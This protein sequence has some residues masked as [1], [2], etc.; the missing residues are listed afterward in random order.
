MS[1]GHI[2][3]FMLLIGAAGALLVVPGW[4]GDRAQGRRRCPRCWYDMSGGGLVCPECGHDAGAERRLHRGRPRRAVMALGALLV[5]A[6]LTP[7]GVI[8]YQRGGTAALVPTTALIA[9]A[10]VLPDRLLWDDRGGRTEDWTL[11][12]RVRRGGT[13]AWQNRWLNGRARRMVMRSETMREACPAW[14]LASALPRVS[15]ARDWTREGAEHVLRIMLEDMTSDDP[16]TRANAVWWLG[17]S[18]V[19]VDLDRMADTI[20]PYADRLLATA[21]DP[22]KTG[23]WAVS[24]AS[25]C[26]PREAVEAWY[27]LLDSPDQTAQRGAYHQIQSEIAREP[28]AHRARLL[29]MLAGP[30][31][32]R[33]ARAAA[34]LAYD[35]AGGDDVTDALLDALDD[36]DDRVCRNA[37]VSLMRQHRAPGLAIDAILDEVETGRPGADVLLRALGTNYEADLGP[38]HAARIAALV[39]GAGPEVATSAVRMLVIMSASHSID[40]SAWRAEL[41]AGAARDDLELPGPTLDWIE[42]LVEPLADP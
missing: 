1:G 6:S 39:P 14:N 4:R 42:G 38:A 18:M 23:V 8:R 19:A 25:V 5:V 20:E 33:R 34:L 40:A 3:L 17:P 12:G 15:G 21:D 13:W 28:E 32:N 37:G 27:G 11:A 31:A 29:E 24:I 22:G 30:D 35:R 16:A 10:G 41:R 2:E 7:L 36:A 26:R 9:G